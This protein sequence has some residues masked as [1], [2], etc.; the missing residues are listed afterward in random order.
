MKRGHEARERYKRKND[1]KVKGAWGHKKV[2]SAKC[3]GDLGS[4]TKGHLEGWGGN[5]KKGKT[6]VRRRQEEARK[7]LYRVGAR[8]KSTKDGIG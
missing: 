8:C 6:T 4:R 2:Q 3:E 5:V 1:A 7:R